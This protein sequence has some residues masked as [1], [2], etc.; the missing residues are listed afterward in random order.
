M[1]GEESELV[2]ISIQ[3]LCEFFVSCEAQGVLV[4]LYF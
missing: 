3:E 2:P 1:R 4:L